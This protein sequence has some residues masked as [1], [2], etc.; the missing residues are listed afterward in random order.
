MSTIYV[1]ISLLTLATVMFGLVWSHDH[2]PVPHQKMVVS[3]NL[4]R[5]DEVRPENLEVRAIS[6]RE[7]EEI[8]TPETVLPSV[9][10]DDI[11]DA[12]AK[13]PAPLQAEKPVILMLNQLS[14]PLPQDLSVGEYRVVN[15]FGDVQELVVE[16]A[17]LEAWGMTGDHSFRTSYEVQSPQGRWHFIR[18]RKRVPSVV[19]QSVPTVEEVQATWAD[20][21]EMAGRF[22]RRSP[23][24]LIGPLEKEDRNLQISS[25]PSEFN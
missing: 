10:A 21:F 9:V 2:Q 11:D 13:P 1:R 25:E 24:E 17:D 19:E 23:Q 6:W 14:F 15:E 3:H 16:S 12:S 5:L 20:V 7:V 8:N 18:I 22:L 4:E